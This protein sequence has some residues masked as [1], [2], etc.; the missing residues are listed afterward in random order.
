MSTRADKLSSIAGAMPVT[1][2]PQ[3]LS[4]ANARTLAHNRGSGWELRTI[5]ALACSQLLMVIEY[6][7]FNSQNAIGQGV[8]RRSG[9]VSPQTG[10]VATG[11][12][13]SLGDASGSPEG[14]AG[15][16]SVTYRGEENLWG[17]LYCYVDG[18]NPYRTA[19]P[20]VCEIYVA[21]HDFADSTGTGAYSKVG[22]TPAKSGTGAY[23]SA[24][25]YSED[26]DWLF[27]PTEMEGTSS[28]PVGD[29]YYI[30]SSS[31][32]KT[33]G[34]GGRW[35]DTVYV[36]VFDMDM[37]SAATNYRYDATARLCYIPP[38]ASGEDTGWIQPVASMGRYYRKIGKRVSVRLATSSGIY[39]MDSTPGFYGVF[40][41]PEGYRPGIDLYFVGE[42]VHNEE[43]P[44][45][46]Q[47][48]ASTGE[49]KVK[50]APWS[51]Q[52]I[53]TTHAVQGCEFSFLVD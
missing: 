37:G 36:G 33:V 45:V 14:T 39:L 10:A 24:F 41:L 2:N 29:G 32:W 30:N 44:V 17:N 22:F 53:A 26:C 50:K 3:Q 31:A 15:Q 47:V 1:G 35:N 46:F 11:G 5:T 16:V 51:T 20:D 12:T 27:V 43:I 52:A 13:S 48:I 25:G 4:R 21:D 7:S 28:L 38:A 40:T 34:N 49:V 9:F 18:I 8:C 19:D 23:I 42:S 6:A